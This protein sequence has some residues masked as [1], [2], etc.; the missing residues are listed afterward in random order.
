MKDRIQKLCKRLSRFTLEEI[1]LIAELDESEI[2]S[3]LKNLVS[4]NFLIKHD[5]NYIYNNIE[6]EAKFKNRLP[7]IFE[8]QSQETIDMIIK[9]FCAEISCEKAGL[10]LSPEK[11]CISDF[12]TFFRKLLYK[13]QKII[14]DQHFRNN[15]QKPRLRQFFDQTFYF[16]YY[17]NSLYVSD[18]LLDAEN[19][20]I[21]STKEIR[22]FKI[23]YS[24]L[25]RRLN[26][27]GARFYPE[28]HLAEQIWR[29]KKEYNLLKQE[30]TRVLFG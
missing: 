4:E 18:E 21:F 12:N 30:L 2:K 20:Q 17:N 28:C 13:N 6:K 9:C 8:Y 26:H 1:A 22:E 14:L 7:M 15:P 16:Y 11:N 23:L 19:A 27:N 3:F 5:N 25:S 24:W 29:H 10:I